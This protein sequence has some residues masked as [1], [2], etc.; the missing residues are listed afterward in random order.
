ML[1]EAVDSVLR[2]TYKARELIVVDDGSEDGTLTRI[3]AYGAA[4]RILSQGR[5]G[6][7]AA[8]NLGVSWASGD[9]LA[10]LD[11]DDLWHPRKLEH[12]TAY[13]A[14][15][16]EMEICQS[17][18]I[19]IRN[20]VRV[21]AKKRHQKP[22]GDIFRASLDL[23]VVSPSTVMMR[24]RLFDRV[25]G[26]DERLRVCEDYDLWLRIARDTP[27]FLLDRALTTKRGGRPDQLSRSTWGFDRFRVM[28]LLKVLDS[29]LD[30]HQ[31]EWVLETLAKKVT[32]LAQGARKRGNHEAATALDR[33]LLEA[34][35][36][37]GT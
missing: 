15:H 13:M 16:P 26:F 25:G 17:G 2:Q 19:W 11:S 22:S 35:Q 32:I 30:A 1:C 33:Q 18:E 6:V 10:F 4:V 28:T 37:Y 24:R 7:S 8:R 27:V 23:C 9:V 29:G 21:N 14:Q 3:S 5:R 20:G 12:Q 34:R 36:K 31:T